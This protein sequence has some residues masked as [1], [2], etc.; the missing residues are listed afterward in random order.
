MPKQMLTLNDFSGG[1][2]TKSSPRDIAPNQV[3]SAENVFLSNPGLIQS[4]SSATNKC[5]AVTLTHTKNGNGAFIFNSQFNVNTDG[6]V[7]DPSQTIAYPIDKDT[8]NTVIQFYRRDFDSTGNFTQEGVN[9]QIDMKVSGAVEPVYYFVDGIL[10]VSDKL[11]V[12]ATA[13]RDNFKKLQYVSTEDRFGT[14]ITGWL[15][16]SAG[17]DMTDVSSTQFEDIAEST[18]FGSSGSTNPSAAGEFSIILGTDPVVDAQDFNTIVLTSNTSKKL[19]TTSNPLDSNPDPTNDIGLESKTIFLTV[20]NDTSDLS[21]VSLNYKDSSNND[22]YPAGAFT[23]ANMDGNIIFINGEGMR[24]RGVNHVDGSATKDIIQLVVDRDVFGTGILEH[25]G[26]SEVQVVSAENISVTAGGWD[27]GSYEFCHTSLDLQG[28][29]TLP[30]RP[31]TDLFTITTGAYFTG[32][33]FRIKDTSFTSRKNE[34]GVRIYTRKKEGNNRWILFLDVDYTRGVRKNLFEDFTEFTHPSDTDYAQVTGIEIINPSLDTY[35]SINGYSQDEESVNITEI[36][37]AYQRDGNLNLLDGAI[38]SNSTTTFNVDTGGLF[39]IGTFIK[40]STEIVK[41]TGV[42]GNALTVTRGQ[43]GTTALSSIANDTQ[44]YHITFGGFKAAAVCARRAWIANVKKNDNVFD[45]RIYYTPV[46]KFSTYPDSFFLDIGISDGDSFTALHSLGN[47]L[48]AFKQKKLYVINVSSTSDSGWYLEAEYDGMGCRQQESVCKTPFGVCW[49]N[50][51][52]VYI[53][54]GQSIPAE[55]TVNLDDSTWRTN[56]TTK[57]PAI[58]YNNK[59]KQLNVVQDT[60]A[61]T[62]VYVYDFPT[63]GWSIVKPF[64]TSNYN[65]ISNFMSSFD[66]LYYLE[67]GATNQKTLKLLSGDVGTESIDLKTKDLDFGNP[68]LVKRIKK[69]FVTV[70]GSGT[71]L[72]LKYANDGETTFATATDA[73]SEVSLGANYV[74]K[75]FT[76]GDGANPTTDKNCESM[77]FELISNGSI[78]INDVNIDYRQTNKRPS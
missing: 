24:V 9:T 78:T 44:I 68:G 39:K 12:S 65:G 4:S 25:A 2:N 40:L 10:Y 17:I 16:S 23:D 54:D 50:D 31:K 66:G 63:R 75:E 33:G 27:A 45:D 73:N 77:A 60:A 59:Y 49:A 64:A 19:V 34:K 15:D 74:I 32:V 58:G 22:V 30:Q 57:N 36:K 76:V 51:D 6:T 69:V 35:E 26:V 47:R 21:S 62:E 67:Y 8:G 14:D 43:A 53:F 28:N 56:Q 52:G 42:S 70:K 3:Q 20:L 71:T 7:T 29:E 61:D 48:L 1:L 46:N 5:S 38:S 11:A 13:G 55:L 37:A 41:V 18:S 72:T